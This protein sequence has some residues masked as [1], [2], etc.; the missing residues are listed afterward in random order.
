MDCNKIIC[1]MFDEFEGAKH[2]MKTYVE[3]KNKK[4]IQN[5]NMFKEMAL[6]EL[7]HF[8]NLHK[9]LI[10]SLPNEEKQDMGCYRML[11]EHY[12]EKYNKIKTELK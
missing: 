1:D 11:H 12:V 5:S 6:N 10:D 9:L 8:D 7:H 2:Y 4:E 3:Y